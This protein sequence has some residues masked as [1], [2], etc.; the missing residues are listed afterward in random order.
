M[1]K[2]LYPAIFIPEKKGGYT[3]EFPDLITAFRQGL[4]AGKLSIPCGNLQAEKE[5]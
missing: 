3:V 5:Y 2:Y 4:A 1:A